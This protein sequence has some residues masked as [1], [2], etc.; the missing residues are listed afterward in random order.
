MKNKNQ[1]E[2]LII[3][4]ILRGAIAHTIGPEAENKVG[5]EYPRVF[6]EFWFIWNFDTWLRVVLQINVIA[7]A[8]LSVYI[9]FT[10]QVDICTYI[11]EYLFCDKGMYIKKNT[12]RCRRSYVCRATENHVSKI[13][14]K[15]RPNR[16]GIPMF[17]L[18]MKIVGDVAYPP[19]IVW[20][21]LAP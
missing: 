10:S 14:I 9:F 2:Y 6:Y 19:H 1:W 18:A 15:I 17:L 12:R 21:P 11:W 7:T 20:Y 13:Q 4:L 16:V 5:R 8:P 3:L